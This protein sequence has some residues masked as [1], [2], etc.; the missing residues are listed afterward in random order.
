MDIAPTL[1]GLLNM[2]YRSCFFGRDILLE[3][4]ERALIAN[5]QNL[6][7]YNGK[8]LAILKPKS[9]I[10]L[11]TGFID[12]RISS[13]PVDRQN[14]LVQQDISYYQT[15]AH[16]FKQHTNAWSS[17]NIL[18]LKDLNQQFTQNVER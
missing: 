11:Q 6:G 7:L 2:S 9:E 8:Q 1:L 12:K 16:V 3:P 17:R 10:A 15:A 18:Q 14:L 13:A 5:Y 4:P